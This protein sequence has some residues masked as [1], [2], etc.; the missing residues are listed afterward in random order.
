MPYFEQVGLATTIGNPDLRRAL[1]Q[2]FDLRW[3]WYPRTG[4][5]LSLGVF[6]KQFDDP[7]EKVIIQ[8]AGTNTLSY[9]N[10]E[11]AEQLRRRAG[12]PEE[13]RFPARTL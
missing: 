10:A 11:K 2:N 13:S 12:G 9:V 3:E 5:V 7:I 8:A 1:I 6:A 4:E